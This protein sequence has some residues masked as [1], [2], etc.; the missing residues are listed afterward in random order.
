M[1]SIE[2][3]RTSQARARVFQR[4]LTGKTYFNLQVLAC[5]AGGEFA[6]VVETGRSDS[7]E[8]VQGMLNMILVDYVATTPEACP[9]CGTATEREPSGRLRHTQLHVPSNLQIMLGADTVHELPA[10]P[11]T[12]ARVKTERPS[13]TVR[14]AGREYQGRVTGVETYALGTYAR[15][16]I[17]RR[18]DDWQTWEWSWSAVARSLNSGK[19]LT[20]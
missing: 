6:V 17:F 12:V 7:Q 8:D 13:V 11:W 9:R 14:H 2:L 18:A 16:T 10:E 5:P 19:P 1:V 3:C 20:T 4:Y 15:V